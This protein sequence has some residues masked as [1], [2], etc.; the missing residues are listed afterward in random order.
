MNFS[1]RE[2]LEYKAAQ[3]G[4]SDEAAPLI[5]KLS[6][7][8]SAM[9]YG[10]ISAGQYAQAMKY[11]PMQMTDVVTSLASGMPL[12]M[13]AIQQGGQIADSFGGLGNIF[14]IIASKFRDVSTSSE[15]AGDSWL[16]LRVTRRKARNSSGHYSV[17]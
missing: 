17:V 16:K 9:K 2:L 15:D 3:L 11:L 10:S 12:W 14:E 7:Q 6:E 8:S 1:T 13:V 5:Q 4:I